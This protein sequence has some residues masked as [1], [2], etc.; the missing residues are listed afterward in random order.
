MIS[1][2]VMK[3][4]NTIEQKNDVELERAQDNIKTDKK[5]DSNLEREPFDWQKQSQEYNGET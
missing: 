4:D 5:E 2:E 3:F 1:D